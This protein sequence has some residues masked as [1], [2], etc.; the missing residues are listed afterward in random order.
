[1]RIEREPVRACVC[2]LLV[3]LGRVRGV[4]R[5]ECS[6]SHYTCLV[7][8]QTPAT[9]LALRRD[10]TSRHVTSTCRCDVTLL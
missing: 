7:D 4:R 10:V 5:S 6:S 1:M 8:C 9:R 3:A 2:V